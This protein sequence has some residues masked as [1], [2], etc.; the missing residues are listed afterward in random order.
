MH[1]EFRW[2][3]NEAE[4]QPRWPASSTGLSAA[5]LCD[6]LPGRAT[7]SY[8]GNNHTCYHVQLTAVT[9]TLQNCRIHQYGHASP[10]PACVFYSG[11]G[12]QT[13]LQQVAGEPRAGRECNSL[14]S[15]R[16]Y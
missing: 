5:Q 2:L 8:E 9:S 16:I 12:I 14:P 3:P 6:G 11:A 10:G 4:P 13:P 7:H 15:L 1:R